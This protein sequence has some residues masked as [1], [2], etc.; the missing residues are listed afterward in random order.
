PSLQRRSKANND[1]G[2]D[3][4]QEP[5]P[6]SSSSKPP[7]P[8]AP[9]KSGS[10]RDTFSRRR[11][12]SR[13]SL[14]TSTAAGAVLKGLGEAGGALM[15]M[16]D[17]E[18]SRL[19]RAYA[20]SELSREEMKRCLRA[21]A[22]QL[23]EGE[24]RT[25]ALMADRE[26]ALCKINAKEEEFAKKEALLEEGKARATAE[27]QQKEELVTS[28]QVENQALQAALE[29]LRLDFQEE[30][31]L[32]LQSGPAAAAAAAAAS[33][34]RPS[35]PSRLGVF[36]RRGLTSRHGGTPAAAAAA[37]EGGKVSSRR[38]GVS[39]PPATPT[40]HNRLLSGPSFLNHHIRSTPGRSGSGGGMLA[41]GGGGGSGAIAAAATPGGV[42]WS[43][44]HGGIGSRHSTAAGA[45]G[46]GR[47]SWVQE[48]AG[49]QAA[50]GLPWVLNTDQAWAG[51]ARP[52][53]EV[54]DHLLEELEGIKA[55]SG[56]EKKEGPMAETA[57]FVEWSH[58][59]G[60][61]QEVPPLEKVD[62][63]GE[64]TFTEGCLKVI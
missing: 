23:R 53:H 24:D 51:G 55:M 60:E 34:V 49:A 62:M 11:G 30:R 64:R 40:R 8:P 29:R 1:G 13:S 3:S 33:K 36:R 6:F 19:R 59:T 7:P 9:R 25:G 35:T 20:R 52:P 2:K 46:A 47:E 22:V 54:L 63:P 58:R 56:G 32:R 12:S 57:A 14:G 44:V 41:G 50:E 15:S 39:R 42:G 28:L 26:A 31:S 18:I 21:L 16:R 37:G 27:A 43:S 61:L 38:E 5:P 10:L 48:G 17:T 4:S 45:A